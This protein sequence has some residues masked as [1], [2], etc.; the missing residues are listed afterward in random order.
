[1]ERKET[2]ENK[3]IDRKENKAEKK[4]GR[5]NKE[6]GDKRRR[7]G[8]IK[9]KRN[10]NKRKIDEENDGDDIEDIEKLYD[11][12]IME[13]I[14]EEHAVEERRKEEYEKEEQEYYAN[15][16]YEVEEDELLDE[17]ESY[18]RENERKKYFTGRKRIKFNEKR[19]QRLERERK[20]SEE[21]ERRMLTK[22]AKENL[23]ANKER[24]ARKIAAR[25]EEKEKLEKELREDEEKEKLEKERKENEKIESRTK[26]EED[27][28]RNTRQRGRSAKKETEVEKLAREEK[29]KEE[30]EKLEKEREGGERHDTSNL[31]T[32]VR[33]NVSKEKP[34]LIE[35]FIPQ[36]PKRK[37]RPTGRGSFRPKPRKPKEEN[38]EDKRRERSRDDDFVADN[39]VADNVVADNVVADNVVADNVV[40][41]DVIVDEKEKKKKEN[42]EKIEKMKREYYEATRI[43]ENRAN[44]FSKDDEVSGNIKPV[45]S[46]DNKRK[47]RRSKTKS[48]D[49]TRRSKTKS[50]DKAKTRRSNSKNRISLGKRKSKGILSGIKSFIFGEKKDPNLLIKLRAREGEKL[51]QENKA[52]EEELR[53]KREEEAR[54]ERE[55]RENR[56][57]KLEEDGKRERERINKKPEKTLTSPKQENR[58]RSSKRITV[59]GGKNASRGKSL[60]KD[61]EEKIKY[62]TNIKHTPKKNINK[63]ET[64]E[65]KP[66]IEGGSF[67]DAESDKEKDEFEDAEIFIDET[68]IEKE[69]GR[70]MVRSKSKIDKNRGR[71]LERNK[72]KGKRDMSRGK[73]IKGEEEDLIFESKKSIIEEEK[74]AL[75]DEDVHNLNRNKDLYMELDFG[76]EE[77]NFN[78]IKLRFADKNP[79]LFSVINKQK[80]KKVNWSK[81]GFPKNKNAEQRRIYNNLKK[82]WSK[83][84]NKLERSFPE[85]TPQ[86]EIDETIERR[87]NEFVIENELETRL[88][89]KRKLDHSD[90]NII[91]RGKVVEK[92]NWEFDDISYNRPSLLMEIMD[93]SFYNEINN[94]N[95]IFYDPIDLDSEFR[96]NEEPINIEFN[97][98]ILDTLSRKDSFGVEIEEKKSIYSEISKNPNER[99]RDLIFDDAEDS[100]LKYGNVLDKRLEGVDGL[101]VDVED[102]ESFLIDL[103]NALAIETS[104]DVRRIN[105]VSG[106]FGRIETILKTNVYKI[107]KTFQSH[108]ADKTVD[109]LIKKRGID[110][111]DLSFI[112]ITFSFSLNL[113][114]ELVPCSIYNLGNFIG[115]EINHEILYV[116][117]N[118]CLD[119]IGTIITNRSKVFI[120][121]N[122][123]FN[124]VDRYLLLKI[125]DRELIP[126]YSQTPGDYYDAMERAAIGEIEDPIGLILNTMSAIYEGENIE[127]FTLVSI[128]FNIKEGDRELKT[129]RSDRLKVGGKSVLRRKRDKDG[130][131]LTQNDKN[132]I[133]SSIAGNRVGGNLSESFPLEL[134][135]L[136]NHLFTV[137]NKDRFCLLNAICIGKMINSATKDGKLD[138]SLK[139]TI[140]EITILKSRETFIVDEYYEFFT[141]KFYTDEGYF[142][143]IDGIDTEKY[144]KSIKY[145]FEHNSINASILYFKR[146]EDRIIIE[147]D[148]FINGDGDIINLFFYDHHYYNIFN[149]HELIHVLKKPL[150]SCWKCGKFESYGKKKLTSHLKGCNEKKYKLVKKKINLGEKSKFF[151]EISRKIP[152][153]KKKFII[154][155]DCEAV[156]EKINIL[157]KKT[158]KSAKHVCSFVGFI[159][160]DISDKNPS[161]KSNNINFKGIV[162]DET[163]FNY[164][165]GKGC[166][167]V[168]INYCNA[169]ALTNECD[170]KV[171]FHNF[172]GYDSHFF[173][174]YIFKKYKNIFTI[175]KSSE[176]Y[177]YVMYE[178]IKKNR[179]TFF[180]SRSFLSQSLEKLTSNLEGK[181]FY[182]KE[183]ELEKLPYPYDYVSSFDLYKKPLPSDIECWKNK[184]STRFDESAV[185]RA[186][187]LNGDC[188]L[189][190]YTLKYLRNDVYMLLEVVSKFRSSCILNYTLDPMNYVT[191]PSYS[192]DC[193]LKSICNGKEFSPSIPV[194]LDGDLIDVIF[195]NIRG[196]IST[197]CETPI[198]DSNNKTIKYFD[199]NN[200]YGWAMCQKLPC[201]KLDIIRDQNEISKKI[202]SYVEGGDTSYFIYCDIA[203]KKHEV[204]ERH[205]PFFPYRKNNRLVLGGGEKNGY[206]THIDM[207]LFA[208]SLGFYEWKDF[209]I[210]YIVEFRQE[211]FIKPYIEKNT[212]LREASKDAADRDMF[213][214]MNNSIYGKTIENVCKRYKKS[215]INSRTISEMPADSIR[216]VEQIS[217]DIFSVEKNTKPFMDKPIFIGFTVLE[218]SK[219]HMYKLFYNVL[220]PSYPTISIAYMDTDSFILSLPENFE[221]PKDKTWFDMTKYKKES[222]HYT[223]GSESKI[224]MLKDEFPDKDIE[225]F[226]ALRSKSYC[227][228]FSNGE[229]IMKN[230]GVNLDDKKFGVNDYMDNYFFQRKLEAKVVRIQSKAH[231][232]NTVSLNKLAL[233]EKKDEKRFQNNLYTTLPLEFEIK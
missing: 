44:L 179:I 156:L 88:N 64:I 75:S 229:V 224:G 84:K 222:R 123:I 184:I 95:D 66:F 171:C 191:L 210:R 79:P 203:K 9:D 173:I 176:K 159:I 141:S 28:G 98:E 146:E 175:P 190:D 80:K 169:L 174:D 14:I 120:A 167:K 46:K 138:R 155:A 47:S 21:N 178:T 13:E 205:L 89:K 137:E 96:N 55:E 135:K 150:Q 1:M 149:L 105:S 192:W 94:K 114:G 27:K 56:R 15:L 223:P 160:L 133:L 182:F 140:K 230:K 106:E 58:G 122:I 12:F 185:R 65:D 48:V 83:K 19:E 81:L 134:S 168:F 86:H 142:K 51:R 62:K 43:Y 228:Q 68:N 4:K 153:N 218:L 115:K 128:K 93:C 61:E 220:L 208:I 110:L 49:K 77:K 206:L 33:K 100:F 31:Q 200:L 3:N 113:R 72:S 53:L 129:K 92:T 119:K 126:Y 124:G 39:V 20:E 172:S 101:G 165:H 183:K 90:F 107:Y 85:N 52:R 214:L 152:E 130:V 127:N 209:K 7:I 201:S 36:S 199:A 78:E 157:N 2:L 125:E 17:I 166:E 221:F 103:D 25:K 207:V 18:F 193:F 87:F 5:G 147:R 225:C 187:E 148:D 35:E 10:M 212:K 102:Q 104:I 40:V 116:I 163:C 45:E 194:M 180:D 161:I 197:V 136:K 189:F 151:R 177:I 188:T 69:R 112:T 60:K 29:E 73:S 67:V 42:R 57:K 213:K 226:I 37:T 154:F 11:N 196:G 233:T 71:T 158:E 97:N 164:F 22:K 202:N 181:Y 109:D 26:D 143:W 170:L 211:T 121:I 82:A 59:K 219:L 204:D 131:I 111:Y 32:Y 139:K 227:I 74:E 217:T 118:K 186:I 34:K 16:Y 63:E 70:E 76:N 198:L 41:D 8:F 132:K 232:I 215:I 195:K 24:M 216:F 162:S 108:F 30:K 23:E 145:I 50:N 91:M 144:E 54:K 99:L 6:G 38:Y 117:I 231:V